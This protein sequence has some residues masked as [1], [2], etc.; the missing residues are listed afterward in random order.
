M[1]APREEP[2]G[3]VRRNSNVTMWL[4][5]A[6]AVAAWGLPIYYLISRLE[7]HDSQLREVQAQ[8]TVSAD[9]RRVLTK[10]V[11]ENK[12]AIAEMREARAAFEASSK[13]QGVEVET[14]FASSE[15]KMNASTAELHR[16]ISIIW[17][18]NPDLGPYPSGP[19]FFSNISQHNR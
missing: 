17:N 12:S 5:V 19:F 4:S 7:R 15:N 9:D 13:A 14:Q 8:N 18:K 2:N 3:V 1:S 6:A 16:L 11:D 10:L